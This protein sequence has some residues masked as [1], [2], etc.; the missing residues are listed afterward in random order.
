[1]TKR[2]GDVILHKCTPSHILHCSWDMARVGCNCY[3]SFWAIFNRFTLL[4]AQKMKKTHLEVSTLTTSVPKIMI[5][6]YTVPE[7]WCARDVIV[8]IHFGL[9]F[10]FLRPPFPLPNSLKN[11]NFKTMEKTPGDIIILHKC[12][13]N[14]DH[15]LYCSWD[16]VC[17]GC[18]CY[19]YFQLCFTLS[20]H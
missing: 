14:H 18:S 2:P 20:P 13:K 9:I 8:I 5:S 4:T 3:F 7:M 12:I 17:V 1:M 6:C 19:F 11:G 16:M 15:R 10:T